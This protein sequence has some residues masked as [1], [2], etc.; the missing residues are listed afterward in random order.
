MVG[1]LFSSR[2]PAGMRAKAGRGRRLFI[3]QL[4][5]RDMLAATW[6]KLA[7]SP[8]AGN[9]TMEL[10]TNGSVLMTNGGNEWSILTPNSSGSYVNGAWTRTS[11][12]DYTRLYDAT[13][14]LAQ[15]QRVRRRRRVRHRFR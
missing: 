4:E 1:N 9:G 5:R 14:V 11:N 8:P 12:A 6:T 3:E 10:L 7:N 13:H 2:Q 15:R